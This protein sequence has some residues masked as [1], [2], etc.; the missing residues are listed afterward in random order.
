MWYFKF[1]KT[2]LLL[3]LVV[4]VLQTQAQE[5]YPSSEP[6]SAMAARS[7]GLRLN[8]ELF[9]A[10]DASQINYKNAYRLNPEIM[11]GI[12]K[13]WM[14]HINL[15]ASNVHQSNFKFEGSNLYVKYRFFSQDDV[16]KHFRMALY[17][18]ASLISNPIQYQEINLAGDNSGIG[19][20]IIATQLLHKVALSFTGGNIRSMNNLQD[21]IVNNQI[22]DAINYSFSTGYLFLP[23][24]YTSYKQTN[25][26]LYVEFIGKTNPAMKESYLDIAPAVQ[27][28]INSVIRLDFI[29]EEAIIWKHVENEQHNIFVSV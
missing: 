1:A 25:V 9:P 18:K 17:G 22:K 7:I 24:N 28:I 27:F 26:N 5:L 2:P 14:M 6:A 10:Y 11:W 13:K 23:F 20:G 21:Q 4:C 8:N 12:N 3:L 15:Y 29:Y 19:T 16:N